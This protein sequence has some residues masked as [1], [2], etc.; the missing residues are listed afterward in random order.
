M[1]F[2]SVSL[3]FY[4]KNEFCLQVVASSLRND[5]I[6]TSFGRFSAVYTRSDKSK[7]GDLLVFFKPFVKNDV[8]C[9]LSYFC[10]VRSV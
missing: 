2:L 9:Y 5:D 10:G 8:F 6:N 1:I 4:I 3:I 7:P